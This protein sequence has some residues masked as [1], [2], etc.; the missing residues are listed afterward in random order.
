[1]NS[2]TALVSVPA[3]KKDYRSNHVG[4]TPTLVRVRLFSFFEGQP[5][6]FSTTSLESKFLIMF[7]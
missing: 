5:G 3:N 6:V 1:M 2:P 4:G 7:P